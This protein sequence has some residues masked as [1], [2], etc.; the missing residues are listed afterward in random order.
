MHFI[1]TDAPTCMRRSQTPHQMRSYR[2]NVDRLLDKS[3]VKTP[4]DLKR[5]LHYHDYVRSK[6]KLRSNTHSNIHTKLHANKKSERYQFSTISSCHYMG[7]PI[8][9]TLSSDESLISC[10]KLCSSVTSQFAQRNLP[11]KN[12][13]SGEASQTLKCAARFTK[14]VVSRCV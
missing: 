4:C 5:V 6:A 10:W 11:F 7:T 13:A 9:P 2:R 12:S 8:N 1:P 3:F 14:I